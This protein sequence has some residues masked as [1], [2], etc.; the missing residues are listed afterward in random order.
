MATFPAAT[1]WLMYTASCSWLRSNFGT[2]LAVL[3][4]RIL[5]SRS[6]GRLPCVATRP[7]I[8]PSNAA[9]AFIGSWGAPALAPA[10]VAPPLDPLGVRPTLAGRGV[11]ATLAGAG[12]VGLGAPSAAA[13]AGGA[14]GAGWWARVSG[15]RTGRGVA[16]TVA[17]VMT[18]AAARGATAAAAARPR[19]SWGVLLRVTAAATAAGSAS[20]EEAT[21]GAGAVGRSGWKAVM[22]SAEPQVQGTSSSPGVEG[23]SMNLLLGWVSQ[24]A[25]LVP[26]L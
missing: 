13:P 1:S 3:M 16:A 7:R 5:C 25:R 10:G 8:C 17:G 23:T 11:S 24:M 19:A 22:T 4:R 15:R 6:R 14:V 2:A 20:P 26:V 18:P 9:I 12:G 21:G